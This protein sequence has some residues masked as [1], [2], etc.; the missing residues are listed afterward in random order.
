MNLIELNAIKTHLKQQLAQLD[1]IQVNCQT[2][3]KL[4][5]G[6]CQEFTAKPPKEWL[7]G[8]VD[9]NVWEWDSIPF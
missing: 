1:K 7:T 2:C 5:S 9:C 4:Q 3:T 8:L 6:V